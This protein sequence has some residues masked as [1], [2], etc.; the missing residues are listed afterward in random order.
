MVMC[1][2]F[3]RRVGA[4]GPQQIRKKNLGIPEVFLFKWKSIVCTHWN[5]IGGGII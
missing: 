5:R 2:G 3:P 4:A 1:P